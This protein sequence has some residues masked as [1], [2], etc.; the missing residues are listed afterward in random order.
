MSAGALVAVVAGIAVLAL[1][2]GLVLTLS[3]LTK[4]V[5]TLNLA[6]DDLRRE[7]LSVVADLRGTVARADTELGRVDTVLGS[8]E[9]ITA[10]V[11]SASRLAYQLFAKPVVK[12]LSISAGTRRA[13]RRLRGTR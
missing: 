6:V 12:L 13:A 8:T 1:V 11:D 7:T 2:V 3:S 10:T 5:R 9:S 4:T